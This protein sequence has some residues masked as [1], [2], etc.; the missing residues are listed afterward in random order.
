MPLRHTKLTGAKMGI[1]DKT[2][3]LDKEGNVTEDPK[4]GATILINE[5]QEVP[6]EM[7]DKYGIGKVAQDDE[8]A[9][10]EGESSNTV[11]SAAPKS[12]KAKSSAK[13][14]AEK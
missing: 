10:D 12:N 14:K 1:V 2:Y 4:K 13:N 8:A 5:G 7:V 11:K 9:G 3:Y 6:K